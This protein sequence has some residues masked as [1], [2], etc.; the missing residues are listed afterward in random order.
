MINFLKVDIKKENPSKREVIN[1]KEDLINKPISKTNLIPIILSGGIGSRLWPLS[2]SAFP[3][4]Y[5]RLDEESKNTLL[6]E[7][8][9]RLK[10]LKNLNNPIIVCN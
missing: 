3:K 4:Q 2:R 10:G 1:R 9:I 6:Q 5:L 7:T 8:Y